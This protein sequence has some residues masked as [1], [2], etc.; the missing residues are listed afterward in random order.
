LQTDY[1]HVLESQPAI[2]EWISSTGMKP[3]LDRL[4]EKEKT[5]FEDEVLSEIKHYYPV[6]KTTVKFF[7]RLKDFFM[8]GY[9]QTA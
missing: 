3:Y 5:Q 4:Q 2:I 6:Q 9:K 1:I 8:I 7:F